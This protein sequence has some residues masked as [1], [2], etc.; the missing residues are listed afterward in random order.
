MLLLRYDTGSN[1][2][3]VPISTNEQMAPNPM[4]LPCGS[5]IRQEH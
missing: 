1:S 2:R 4:T 5:D 3:Q